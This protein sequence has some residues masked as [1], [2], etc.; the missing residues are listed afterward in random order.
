MNGVIEIPDAILDRGRLA[1]E[2]EIASYRFF[3]PFVRG[4]TRLIPHDPPSLHGE[5]IE[6]FFEFYGWRFFGD[7]GA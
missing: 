6:A 4:V 1:S 7:L 3:G 2:E 5:L